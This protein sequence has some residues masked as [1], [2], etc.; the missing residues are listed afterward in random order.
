MP[1][2]FHVAIFMLL[3]TSYLARRIAYHGS[4]SRPPL[5]ATVY[6]IGHSTRP[7]AELVS[8]LDAHKVR[9]LADVRTI[10]RSRHNPQF[11][12]D[13]LAATLAAAGI[14]YVHMPSL[15]G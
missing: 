2:T 11:N 8:L 14:G 15:G 1:L 9:T 3:R 12:A 5:P 7:V 10:P 4:V 6:T 13:A